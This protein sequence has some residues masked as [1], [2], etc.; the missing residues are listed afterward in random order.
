M[1]AKPEADDAR[2]EA[3]GKEFLDSILKWH[4]LNYYWFKLLNFFRPIYFACLRILANL[5]EIGYEVPFNVK[6]ST[7]LNLENV[8]VVV[9]QRS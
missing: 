9:V 5:L 6:E 4:S 8:I 2:P 7:S 1:L 3:V